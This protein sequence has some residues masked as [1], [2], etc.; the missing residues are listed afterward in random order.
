[1][2][3]P[4]Y[5]LICRGKLAPL[6]RGEGTPPYTLPQRGATSDIYKNARLRYNKS[7]K[8]FDESRS[9]HAHQFDRTLLQ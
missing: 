6:G 8:Y 2:L 5:L 3:P 1:M 4:F 9:H 7:Y